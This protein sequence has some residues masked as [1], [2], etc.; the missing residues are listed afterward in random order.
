[1][2]STAEL[3]RSGW[4]PG[5][6]K[7]GDQVTILVHPMRD[8]TPGAHFLSAAGPDGTPLGKSK[9]RNIP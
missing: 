6:V 3:Y 2:G 4:R 5:T 7:A 1:M 9:T 8:G